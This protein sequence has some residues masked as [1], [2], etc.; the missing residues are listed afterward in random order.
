[1]SQEPN[2]DYSHYTLE[3]IKINEE[4]AKKFFEIESQILSIGNF[5]D[6]FESLL[7]LIET[8]FGVPHVWLSIINGSEVSHVLQ[9]LESSDLLKK[10]LNLV[11]K[12]TFLQLINDDR[13]PILVNKDLKP[14]YKLLPHKKKYFVKSLAIAP[15]FYEENVIGSLNLGDY[16]ASRFEPSMDIFFL[17]QLSVKISICIANIT[18]HEKLLRLARRDALTGLLNRKEMDDILKAEF[19][20]AQNQG[21]P[22]SLIFIDYND[23]K[24]VNESYGYT[25]GDGLLH[26]LATQ[27]RKTIHKDGTTFRFAGDQFVVILPNGTRKE[28]VKLSKRLHELFDKYPM[29]YNDTIIPI[30]FSTGVASMSDSGMTS[31]LS[32]LEKAAE[33]LY[34]TKKKSSAG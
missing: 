10:R 11:G 12:N 34:E 17:R 9:S 7:I 19:A 30:S 13:T 24:S 16:S 27:I 15:L 32:L 22:L 3:T 2:P 1:M 25:C 8:K 4:I 20:M 29:K 21:T 14:Y 33:R 6:F 18:A 28:A 5:K 31:P 26:Y 23:L